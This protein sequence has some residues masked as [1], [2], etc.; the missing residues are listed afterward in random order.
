M[1]LLFQRRWGSDVRSLGHFSLYPSLPPSSLS[2]WPDANHS[3]VCGNPEVIMIVNQAP[4]CNP[5]NSLSSPL[6]KRGD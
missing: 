1:L 4:L 2:L 5:C 6:Y 3:T